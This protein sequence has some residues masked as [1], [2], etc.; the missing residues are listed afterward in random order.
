[1]LAPAHPHPHLESVVN[2][3][4]DSAL[5]PLGGTREI[6]S[7]VESSDDDTEVTMLDTGV[8]PNTSTWRLHLWAICMSWS[9]SVTTP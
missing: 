9:V 8:E 6:Q 1:M 2:G 7:Q 3:Q 4:R 5:V